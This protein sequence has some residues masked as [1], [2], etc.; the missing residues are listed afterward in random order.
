M[1]AD[2]WWLMTSS[3]APWAA[4]YAGAPVDATIELPGSKSMTARALVIAAL[5]DGTATVRR[6]LRS[7]DTELMAAG[8]RALGASVEDSGAGDWVVT[9]TAGRPVAVAGS[10]DVGLAGTVARFLPPVAALAD[11]D[12]GFTGDARMRE[13]PVA[14]L[15]QAMRD[16]GAKVTAPD[17]RF[18][19]TVH[20]RG[21]LRGGAV[22]VDASASSQLVSG[23]L[24]AAPCFA[25][26]IDLRHVG[27]AV[28]SRPHLDM[29]VAMMHAAGAH[30]VEPEPDRWQVAPTGYVATD[31]DVEPDL[32]GAS[33]FLAAA[34][35][36][37]GVVRVPSWPAE[38]TQPGRHL[39]DVLGRM[40]ASWTLDTAGLT[41][42]GPTSIAGVDADLRDSP[43]MTPAV[44]V[45]AALAGS[46]SRLT[47]VAHIR[48]QET[49]R[50]HALAV[51]LGR[52]GADV[53]ELPDGLVVRPAPLRGAA[54]RAYDDHRLAMAWAVLG[55]VVDGVTVDDVTTTAKTMPDFTNRWTAMLASRRAAQ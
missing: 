47:G 41:L 28:P 24:L 20:G 50:I 54:L 11:R 42:Q 4:P 13:R 29:T 7:R 23:L 18:P 8:V 30:A 49:D 2:R 33:P 37:G 21:R 6:P 14:A 53:D 45:L 31:V 5:A 9:G 52:L 25:D 48:G 32:S 43:E 40:G 19:F 44:A 46:P 1:T 36:T 34:V 35:A 17:D 38:S 26:G 10:V 16:L 39:L 22:Q 12:V 55:L 3:V 27:D 51:E 15:L